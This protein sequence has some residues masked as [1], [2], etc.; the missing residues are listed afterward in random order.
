MSL[1]TNALTTLATVKTEL[2][3][4]D[5]SKDDQLSRYI[6]VI[7]DLIADYCNRIFYWEEDIEE[8]VAGFAS[9]F[10]VVSR[11]P[12]LEISSIEYDGEELDATTY[13]IDTADSGKIYR[14]TPWIWTARAEETPTQD[15]VPGS[16]KKLYTVTYDG[17]YVTPEQEGAPTPVRTLPWVL[18][19]ACI[20][21][22]VDRY[23]GSGKP[24][25]IKSE[26]LLSWSVG[27][28]GP[29]GGISEELG[30]QLGLNKY[31]RIDIA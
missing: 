19:D 16:E 21:L 13:N 4:A 14:S 30:A 18:E 5:A 3:I 29:N 22:V 11:T 31:R 15:P 17:G 24:T 7:S 20:R 25:N 8:A 28:G 2:G 12:L 23:R 6:N 9:N 27:Y 10:L 26:K 1:A